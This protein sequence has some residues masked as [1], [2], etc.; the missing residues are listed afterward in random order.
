MEPGTSRIILTGFSGSGKSAVAPLIAEKLGWQVVDT[1]EIVERKAGKRILEIFASEGEQRFRDLEAEAVREA[2]AMDRVVISTGGG[3]VLRPANRELMARSGVVVCLEARPETIFERLEDRGEEEPL[4]RPLLASDQPLNRIRKLKAGRQQLYALCDWTVHTDSLA[5]DE[6]A[7]EVLRFIE[8]GAGEA[9]RRADRVEALTAPW[10]SAPATTLHALPK[11][12]SA[13]VSAS[14]GDYP[15]V[16]K[17]GALESLGTRL[18]SAGLSRFAYVVSDETVW[19]HVGDE[20]EAALGA[21]EIPFESITIAPGE[22][23]KTLATAQELYTWL[24]RHKAERGHVVVAVGGGVVTDLGGFVAATFA[25]GLPLVHVP[26]S[27]LGQVDAA[28]GGKVAVNLP[29]AKNMVGAFYQPRMVLADPAVLR[30]LQ[31]REVY[32]GW[33]EAIKH[34]FIAD[35]SYLEFFEENAD[36]ILGLDPELTTEAIRRSVVIKAQVVSEDEKETT[37]RRSHLNYGHTLAHAIESTT[38]YQRFRHG[39]A[40]GIGMTAAGSMSVRMGLLAP[41]VLDRQRRLLER[42]KLPTHA[43]RPRP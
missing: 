32:S 20:V 18:R 29:E 19:H 24:I 27:L 21:A 3:V 35:E 36:A 10:L 30:T 14:T 25:R 37:G 34:A 15:V 5:P 12:A 8:T 28:I 43:E 26:T 22:D 13:V 2:C 11:D 40:D 17:W 4:D 7:A 16:V 41:E 1:D 39:E 42:F 33:A 6:V 9:L 31:P 38:G 23:S